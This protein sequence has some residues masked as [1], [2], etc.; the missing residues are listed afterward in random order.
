MLRHDCAELPLS[1]DHDLL[2]FDIGAVTTDVV[3][4]KD[5]VSDPS[6]ANLKR[7][8]EL[9]RGPFL[10]GLNARSDLF[11]EWLLGERTR[12]RAVATSAFHTL[13]QELLSLSAHGRRRSRWR[14]VCW[15]SIRCRKRWIAP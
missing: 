9:Y 13:L 15:R 14:S 5:A 4:F 1:A 2:G 3:E 12:L 10:E 8:A 11:D 6:I 7:A